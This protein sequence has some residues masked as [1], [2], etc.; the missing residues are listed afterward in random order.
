MMDQ[1]PQMMNP[2]D[3]V[4]TLLAGVL[5]GNKWF[6]AH[7][8]EVIHQNK[9]DLAFLIKQ[10][11]ASL[12][13][14]A[15]VIGVDRMTNMFTGL[16]CEITVTCTEH[17]MM[18]R[19]KQGFVTAIDVCQAAIQ[20]ID[21]EWWHFLSMEH[22]TEPETDILQATATFKGLVDRKFQNPSMEEN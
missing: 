10:K 4:Q 14:V 18:N 1:L 6:K 19:A 9:Q 15:L 13:H 21:G 2:I 17:V 12:N 5:K 16:E 20:L 3:Q 8:V 7:K 11:M 22:T